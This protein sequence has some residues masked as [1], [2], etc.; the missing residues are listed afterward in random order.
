MIDL[1]LIEVKEPLLRLN[2]NFEE[3]ENA[4]DLM[5]DLVLTQNIRNHI[6]ALSDFPTEFLLSENEYCR[7]YLLLT[8]L[9]HSYL[10][11]SNTQIILKVES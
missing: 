4:L 9:S 8:F 11:G 5:N 6:E 3:W 2:N 1:S 7:A 10:I